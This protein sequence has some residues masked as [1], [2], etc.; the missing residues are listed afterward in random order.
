LFGKFLHL[1]PAMITLGRTLF[2][3]IALVIVSLLLKTDLRVRNGRHFFGFVCMGG[4]L[5]VH[6]SSFFYAV[7]VSTVA[8]ALLSYS[9]FPVFVTF[10]EPIVFN[11]RLRIVDILI[12]LVVFLGLVLI[13]PEFSLANDVTLGVVWGTFS[14]F[15]F[16]AL[17]LLNRKFVASYSALTVAL[18]QDAFAS[19]LLL[20]FVGKAMLRLPSLEW[21]GLILLGVVF[22]ALAHWLFIR[23]M[24][25]IKAQLAGVIACLEP[26]YG[27]LIALAVLQEIPSRREVLGGVVIIV[28]IV[29][30]TQ[31]ADTA[32]Q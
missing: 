17:S 21:S 6:W 9:S 30:A 15:T 11:E 29:Y 8:I 1:A 31:K 22:T 25:G 28:A 27:I 2:A 10:M 7:Q 13:V 24:R 4:I 12:A 20:P 16:A 23:G 26:V 3:G 19:L 5:A 32:L 14:G 18:Y